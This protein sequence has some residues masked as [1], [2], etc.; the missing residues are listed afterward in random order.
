MSRRK[1][2]SPFRG[3]RLIIKL[4]PLAI[5]IL[6]G[7]YIVNNEVAVNIV[8]KINPQDIWR[9][10][11]GYGIVFVGIFNILLMIFGGMKRN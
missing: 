10:I 11:L 6:I 9:Q 7:L 8:S 3:L 1:E 5:A 2:Q 4:V